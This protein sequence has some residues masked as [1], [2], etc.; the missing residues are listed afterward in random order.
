MSSRLETDTHGGFV[1]VQYK[2]IYCLTTAKVPTLDAEWRLEDTAFN[3]TAVVIQRLM[4]KTSKIQVQVTEIMNNLGRTLDNVELIL[5]IIC[6]AQ[7]VDQEVTT[8][9][10]NVPENW[11]YTTVAWEDNVL[12]RDY[13]KA[14]VF[15]GRVDVYNDISMARVMNE[16]RACR[17]ILHSLIVRCAAWICSPVDY[18]TTLEYAT[19]ASVCRDVIADIIASVPYHFGWHL[20]RKNVIRNTSISTFACGEEDTPKGLAG[21]FVTWPLTCV[22][23]QDYTTDTQRAWV[24]A[25]RWKRSR[26]QI[27]ACPDSGMCFS[28]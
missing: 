13:A 2:T 1:D 15:P 6:R 24:V 26:Y 20:K 18:R 3:K 17:L 27:C 22:V 5:D 21:Y 16:A 10:Q 4:I 8:W 19:A 14:E 12:N 23:A 7:A 11:H 25:E 9:Q 28:T